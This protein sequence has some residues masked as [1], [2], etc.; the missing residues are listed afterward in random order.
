MLKMYW[1]M[2]GRT[3]ILD[4]GMERK[5][6]IGAKKRGGRER[7]VFLRGVSRGDV[8]WRIFQRWFN[9]RP[10]PNCTMIRDKNGEKFWVSCENY[11][12]AGLWVWVYHR[13][14]RIGM[15]KSTWRE[16]GG[17]EIGEVQI[18]SA[19][20]RRRGVGHAMM[21]FFNNVARDLG[22]LS[23]YAIIAPIGDYSLQALVAWYQRQGF[24]IVEPAPGTYHAVMK[25]K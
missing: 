12:G 14:Q 19:R 25:L 7:D 11:P 20:F 4:W 23:I 24:R 17:L 1:R 3:R 18:Y 21:A 5:I 9:C 6:T 8:S 15:I 13:D 16:T 10:S 2:F 22:A